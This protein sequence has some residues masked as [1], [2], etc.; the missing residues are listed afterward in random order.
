M[1]SDS[2]RQSSLRQ[3]RDA[4]GLSREQVCRRLDPPVSTKTLERWED[5]TLPLIKKRWR[6]VQLATIYET[7]PGELLSSNG[8]EAA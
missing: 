5:D 8:K 3:A 1:E 2:S 7:S 6:L 4:T